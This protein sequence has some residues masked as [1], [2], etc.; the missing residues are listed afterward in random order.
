MNC[1]KGCSQCCSQIFRITQFDAYGI[2]NHLG[3][4]NTEFKNSLKKKAEDYLRKTTSGDLKTEDF[5]SEPKLPCPALNENGACMIYEAR[6]VICRRFG[7]PVYDYKNPGKLF[8]CELNFSDGEEITDNDLIPH[9]T[10]I[11]K[12]WDDL[13]TI[14]NSQNSLDINASTTI[15]E[16]I[17]DS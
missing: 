2:S 1:R 16:A 4:V 11:G 6:P 12:K 3:N 7:P 15:A 17:L 8:A 14:F 5:F 13:K 9:Q 10:K